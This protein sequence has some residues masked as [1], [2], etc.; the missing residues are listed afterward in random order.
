M[1]SVIGTV[2]NSIPGGSCGAGCVLVLG[3]CRLCKWVPDSILGVSSM[4]MTLR[5]GLINGASRF[6]FT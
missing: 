1:G 6:G 4:I 3:D 2:C 5:L